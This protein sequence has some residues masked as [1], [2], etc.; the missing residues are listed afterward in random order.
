MCDEKRVLSIG[1]VVK[2]L[3]HVI[4]AKKFKGDEL[5]TQNIMAHIVWKL[6]AYG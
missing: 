5:W 4:G 6:A 2:L 1:G 3:K